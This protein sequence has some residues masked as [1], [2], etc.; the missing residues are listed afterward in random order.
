M[1]LTLTKSNKEEPVIAVGENVDVFS[2]FLLSI[3]YS[4]DVLF[5]HTC[6]H[7]R[8]M[9][10]LHILD[11]SCSD[12]CIRTMISPQYKLNFSQHSDG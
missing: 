4:S 2:K 5:L 3:L 9:I 6:I 8:L 7:R 12:A 11:L 1:P 10:N